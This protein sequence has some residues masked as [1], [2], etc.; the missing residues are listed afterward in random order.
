[1]GPWDAVIARTRSAAFLPPP[2]PPLFPG[3]GSSCRGGGHSWLT[4]VLSGPQPRQE[5]I[6]TH[7]RSSPTGPQ[8][9]GRGNK[10]GGTQTAQGDPRLGAP[11]PLGA[12]VRAS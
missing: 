4:S 9:F 8:P 2:P 7:C 1:M 12:P 5:E 11:D 3:R 6:T 10:E